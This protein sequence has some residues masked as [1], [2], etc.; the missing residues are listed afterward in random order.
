MALEGV[1]HV[2]S[3]NMDIQPHTPEITW[4]DHLFYVKRFHR[5]VTVTPID[6]PDL[7]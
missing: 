4:T 6:F 7:T 1:V 5:D 3:S 2:I